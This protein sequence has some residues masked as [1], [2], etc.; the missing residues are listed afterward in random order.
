M[1]VSVTGEGWSAASVRHAVATV[2]VFLGVF[3]F[4]YGPPLTPA[5]ADA[6]HRECNRM[7][8]AT[9]RTYRLEWRTTSYSSMH[10]PEWV[11]RNTRDPLDAGT[12]LGWWTGV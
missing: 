4:F 8:G 11:C 10:R 9:Y 2:L 7:T 3:S 5:L 6:A 12:S 1:G